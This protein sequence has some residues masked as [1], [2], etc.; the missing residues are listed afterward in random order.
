MGRCTFFLEN[1]IKWSHVGDQY[2]AV[3]WL[4]VGINSNT[5]NSG[6]IIFPEQ[7]YISLVACCDFY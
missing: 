3:K 2:E 5:D 1:H 4:R 6:F 7:I